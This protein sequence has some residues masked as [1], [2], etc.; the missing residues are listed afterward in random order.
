MIS[1]GEK[2]LF[3]AKGDSGNNKIEKKEFHL[4]EL[5]DEVVA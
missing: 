1:L 4:N 3:L 2:L 5:I